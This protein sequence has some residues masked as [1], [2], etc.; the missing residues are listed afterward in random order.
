MLIHALEVE[1]GRIP[2]HLLCWSLQ[3]W[4][5]IRAS[6][7]PSEAP[8]AKYSKPLPASLSSKNLPWEWDSIPFPLSG[9]IPKHRKGNRSEKGSPEIKWGV[10]LSC[11]VHPRTFLH[12]VPLPQLGLWESR[13]NFVLVQHRVPGPNS[14]NTLGQ[15]NSLF[16]RMPCALQDVERHPQPLSTRCQEQTSPASCDNSK[17]FR[18]VSDVPWKLKTALE[19]EIPCPKRYPNASTKSHL[20]RKQMCLTSRKTS[21]KDLCA[22]K[23]S[24]T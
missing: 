9:F 3:T 8:L 4:Q 23:F 13:T 5:W 2:V 15:D 16:Q 12:C 11:K 10:F 7:S 1:G 19:S 22:R 6:A 24:T 14:V 20:L 17:W 21:P 18:T